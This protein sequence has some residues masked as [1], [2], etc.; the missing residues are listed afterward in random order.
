[1]DH[2]CD[3]RSHVLICLEG[4]TRLSHFSSERPTPGSYARTHRTLIRPQSSSRSEISP[5]CHLRAA[6]EWVWRHTTKLLGTHSLEDLAREGEQ[7][8]LAGFVRR[9]RYALDRSTPFPYHAGRRVGYRRSRAWEAL[10]TGCLHWRR[11]GNIKMFGRDHV[12]GYHV[13][14]SLSCATQSAWWAAAHEGEW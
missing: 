6:R 7:G 8:D 14:V 3:C 4:T 11:P 2:W 9:Q 13:R 1:M 12:I 5:S 10:L